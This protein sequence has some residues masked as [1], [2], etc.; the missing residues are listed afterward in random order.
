[1]YIRIMS[2]KKYVA[3]AL[4]MGNLLS[5]VLVIL[6]VFIW[7]FGA[8]LQGHLQFDVEPYY[9]FGAL[10]HAWLGRGMLGLAGI[11]LVGQLFDLLDGIAA[12]W[13]GTDG[14]MGRQL[15]SIADA[16]SSGVTPAVVG[17]MMLHAWAPAIPEPLKFLPLTI[18][19]AAAYRLARFNVE[20]AKG[21]HAS[22]FSGMPAPAGALWWIGTLLVG[23]QYEIQGSWGSSGLGSTNIILVAIF[24]GSSLI[25][26]WMVS[27]RPMLDLKRWGKD[28]DFDRRR[29]VFL[30]GV[31]TAGLV[32]AFFGRALGLGILVGLLLYALCGAYIKK[33]TDSRP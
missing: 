2:A 8:P 31:I 5:G 33:T 29:A 13:A 17:V 23:A 12:R 19:V 14:V 9:E 10:S 18:A 22:G 28:P 25:P 27:R 26:W 30:G 11:W 6:G 16:V 1:M 4:T 32:S 7:P 15:D 21:L 24:I 3:N 20:A